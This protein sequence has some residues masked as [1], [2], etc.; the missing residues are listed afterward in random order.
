MPKKTSF[1]ATS[2]AQWTRQDL[3]QLPKNDDA[4]T[5]ILDLEP[6]DMDSFELD[7][8][9]DIFNKDVNDGPPATPK[10]QGSGPK[11][12][13]V[14]PI[15]S[16]GH[17]CHQQHQTSATHSFQEISIVKNRTGFDEQ[18]FRDE[19]Q[20]QQ[21]ELGEKFKGTIINAKHVNYCIGI[22]EKLYDCLDMMVAD[23]SKS[24]YHQQ[25][26][27]YHQLEDRLSSIRRGAFQAG[28][29]NTVPP[30]QTLDSNRIIGTFYPEFY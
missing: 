20:K 14:V 7:N 12:H 22:V 2:S 8:D 10:S 30:L 4:P 5:A 29:N 13:E 24:I 21:H 27:N 1:L 11:G 28:N 15:T 18:Q 25:T 26:D 3:H 17:N 9:D 23:V 6:I 19:C 16:T